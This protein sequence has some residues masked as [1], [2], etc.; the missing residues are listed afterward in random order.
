MK[1]YENNESC[2]IRQSL[3]NF[4]KLASSN[5]RQRILLLNCSNENFREASEIPPG[6]KYFRD[7][8]T[9][10]VKG[11]FML[12]LEPADAA[13]GDNPVSPKATL[14]AAQLPSLHSIILFMCLEDIYHALK[15]WSQST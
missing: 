3:S 11:A 2:G 4:K 15:K 8:S 10:G 7:A 13:G 9:L 12:R 1:S 5:F 14:I 6:H